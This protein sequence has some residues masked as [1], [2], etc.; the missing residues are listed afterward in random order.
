MSKEK[1]FEYL[2]KLREKGMVIYGYPQALCDKFLDMSYK[3][4]LDFV[5]E[6]KEKQNVF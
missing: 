6:W 3:D 1:A 4:A 5:A 2:D